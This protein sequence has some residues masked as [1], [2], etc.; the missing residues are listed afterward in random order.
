MPPNKL[1]YRKFKSFDK[2]RFFKDVSNLPEKRR[3]AIKKANS[4]NDPLSIKLYKK[5]KKLLCQS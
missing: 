3:S 5:T 4:L 2:I 1:R